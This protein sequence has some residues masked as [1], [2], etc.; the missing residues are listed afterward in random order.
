MRI[1]F[2][3][4][5]VPN[6]IRVRPYNL[7]RYLTAAGHKVT[8][9]TLWSNEKERE[10][11]T[12]LAAHCHRVIA[13]PLPRWQSLWSCLL[14]LPQRWP[15]QSAYCW[16]P[17]LARELVALAGTGHEGHSPYDIVHVEHL[18]GARY[19]LHY[20]QYLAGGAPIVWDSVDCISHL[21]RQTAARSKSRL[22]R[23]LARLELDRTER[24]EAWLAGQFDQ[25]LVTSQGD[26]AALEHLALRYRQHPSPPANVAVLP[27]GVDLDYFEPGD[28]GAR[29]AATLVISGKMSYHANVTMVLHFLEAVM[30]RIWAVRP[31]TRLN[32]VGK[33]PSRQLLAAARRPNV[34]VTGAVADIRPYLQR[35]TIAVA[36]ILY[37]AGIQNKVLEAMACATPVVAT[38]QAASALPARPGHDLIVA[39]DPVAFAEGVLSLL[40][41]PERARLFGRNGRCY[42]EEHHDWTHVAH[43]LAE[44]YAGAIAARKPH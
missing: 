44:A 21:F 23:S 38:P 31:E 6:L 12:A 14:A 27:N 18:R 37:G 5:Y 41:A 33:D 8:V 19:G 13:L 35:A 26:R 10:S 16:Q 42:V 9:L 15:L 29:A 25:V 30:P 24:Y 28:P 2:V 7:I 20:R 1:L 32:I 34:T 40:A 22:S 11:A 4:P 43:Q 39:E 3:V 36:P 17:A